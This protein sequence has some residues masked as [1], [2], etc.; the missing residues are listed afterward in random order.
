M[1]P[2]E[3]WNTKTKNI[4]H[5]RVGR[6]ESIMN[7]PNSTSDS[8][9]NQAGSLGAPA[10]D[11]IAEGGM[12]PGSISPSETR[13][14]GIDIQTPETTD[15]TLARPVQIHPTYF[16]PTRVMSPNTM[17]GNTMIGAL[18]NDQANSVNE[19]NTSLLLGQHLC[20]VC[21]EIG[22]EMMVCAECGMVGHPLCLKMSPLEGYWS[23]AVV[24]K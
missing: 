6:E 9:W 20:Q 1:L 5:L 14:R 13:L 2:S 12:D 24:M 7:S 23:A 17:I 16:A 3:E 11:V 15:N 21:S 19:I 18:G 10:T 4:H 8:S 22:P